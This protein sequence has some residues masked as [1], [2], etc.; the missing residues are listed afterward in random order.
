[1]M[2]KHTSTF[3]L[4][5]L[6]TI[7]MQAQ[8]IMYVC[9]GTNYTE[10]DIAT[11]GEMPFSNHGSSLTLRGVTYDVATID[12]IT[13]EKPTFVMDGKV[14]ITYNETTASVEVPTTISGITYTISNADVVVTSTNISDDIEYVIHGSSTNGS[15]NYIGNYKCKFTFNGLYLTSESGAAI[16]IDCS[17][18]VAMV[19]SEGTVNTL[20]D[21][22]SGSHK[23]ALYCKGHMEFEGAGTLNVTGNY[24]HAISGKEY[25]Q[26]KKSTGT[27]NITKSANDGIH[28]G[29][30]F[31]MNGG[32]VNISGT[33][34]DCIQA[35]K[36]SD[37][38]DEDNGQ[39]I[40]KGGKLNLSL[41]SE[42]VK[43]LKSDDLITISGGDI[44]INVTGNGSKA[45]ST[46][47]DLVINEKNNPTT[48][49][50]TTSGTTYV[51]SKGE[52]KYC[53]GINIEGNMT[54]SAGTLNVTNIGAEGRGIKVDQS[55]IV[56]GGNG[57]YLASGNA[58]KCIRAEYFE[59]NAGEMNFT[60]SGVPIVTNYDPSYCSA[61]KV[62]S[63]IQN[64]GTL[65]MNC[66]GQANKGISIDGNGVINNGIIDI[67]TT[68][69]AGYYNTG[70]GYDTYACSAIT[71]DGDLSII[72]GT[73]TLESTGSGGK[74]INCDQVL[75][76]GKD[77]GTGPIMSVT[78]SGAQ[79]SY[80]SQ[81][82]KAKAI[83]A[84]GDIYVH[85][86]DYSVST[87]RTEAEG[88]ESKSNIYFN[89]G[90]LVVV[91][92]DDAIN[93][94]AVITFNG[95]RVY[96]QSTANDAVDSNYGQN[97]AIIINDGVLI[98][99]GIR[100]PE[101]ALDADNHSWLKFNGGTVF[102]MGGNQGGGSS[103]AP[104]CTQG[105]IYLQNVSLTQNHY[106]TITQNNA[107]VYTVKIPTTLS[108][109]YCF[110]SDEKLKDTCI[111]TTS[112]VAPTSYSSE[113]QGLYKGANVTTGTSLAS[114]SLT[115]NYGTNGNSGN[116]PR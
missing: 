90:D 24:K 64:G 94:A 84:L 62:T 9:R 49:T 35:E 38:T 109:C 12:S 74:G 93:A 39:M 77:D 95:S 101:E 110:L 86:G 92:Y 67:K 6:L 17:K 8:Q 80:G 115:N 11:L 31:Q 48:I 2:K 19:L 27:I 114:V 85:G 108:Q 43:A 3:I 58:S 107:N 55:F 18:R 60:T 70:S 116:R 34:G 13:F 98:A 113:W 79:Y 45:I 61:I 50:I 99:I 87:S 36:T 69:N 104:T 7:S 73:L 21:A 57:T 25:I 4:F 82:A 75:T 5:I 22:E 51:N 83:K 1:M 10:V 33:A 111:I 23:A 47:G 103:S 89:G 65:T 78:T 32:T 106:L 105:T 20:A 100:S 56:D 59:M 96:A 53:D 102:T 71:C 41:A 40:I 14:V 72:N 54:F 66:N 29:Q 68:G 91:A 88:I 63:F 16:N 26:L 46:D 44:T 30:Y 97:G 37:E 112:T 52:S 42:D 15:L 81:T 28:A 76:M